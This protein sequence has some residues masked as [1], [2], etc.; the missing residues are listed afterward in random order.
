MATIYCFSSTGN[1]LYVAKRISEKIN[2]SLISMTQNVDVC[3]DDMIGFVFPVYFWGLPKIV[4]RFITRLK[5]ANDK[6]YVFTIATYGSTIHGVLGAVI[7]IMTRKQIKLAYGNTLKSV[8]N[9]IPGYKVNDTESFQKRIDEN[10]SVIVNE[11]YEKRHNSPAKSTI[12]NRIIS[13]MN[14]ANQADCDQYFTVSD[15]CNGCGVCQN[16]CPVNNIDIKNVKP[17]FKHSCEHCLACIHACPQTA[18][19]WKTKTIG[20]ER[21]RN[22]H[23][24]LNEIITFNSIK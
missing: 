14:P 21:Y 7:K 13:S 12:L 8:E 3:I 23:V 22:L 20:K 11:I 9:Y 10:L 19:E 5:I 6:A 18:I 24:S 4:E 15:Y 2:A 1:S 17:V 16:V